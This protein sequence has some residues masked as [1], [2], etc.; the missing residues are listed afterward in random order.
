MMLGLNAHTQIA[1]L[2]VRDLLDMPAVAGMWGFLSEQKKL[3]L[4]QKWAVHANADKSLRT[5]KI[6]A[7]ALFSALGGELSKLA[8]TEKEL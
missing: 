6:Q 4:C 1:Y 7:I 8:I 2:V 3:E 5:Q